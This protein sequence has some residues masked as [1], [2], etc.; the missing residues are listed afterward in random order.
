MGSVDRNSG[1]SA[2]CEPLGHAV[3]DDLA[4]LPVTDAE[5]DVIEAFLAK[6]LRDLFNEDSEPPQTHVEIAA[7][8]RCPRARP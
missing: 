7:I 6:A 8:P 1:Q 2:S 5:L 4:G 3:L